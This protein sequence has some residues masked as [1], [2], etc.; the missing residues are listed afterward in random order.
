M[1]WVTWS[2]PMSSSIH[3]QVPCL[4]LMGQLP[5]LKA[6]LCYSNL[7]KGNVILNIIMISM[8]S[9]VLRHLSAN[10]LIR[11]SLNPASSSTAVYIPRSVS[12]LRFFGVKKLH[13]PISPVG[14]FNYPRLGKN[15]IARSRPFTSWMWQISPSVSQ[16]LHLNWLAWFLP[17]EVKMLL[18]L[19]HPQIPALAP[20]LSQGWCGLLWPCQCPLLPRAPGDPETKKLPT[21]QL[22][23]YEQVGQ[24]LPVN[25]RWDE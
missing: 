17:Q 22:G 9:Y 6:S 24:I 21:K 4:L 3:V 5:M 20:A 19:S 2:F 18:A 14:F 11:V 10:L 23:W 16:K 15:T 1:W 8:I 7:T 25:Y 13:G 12:R